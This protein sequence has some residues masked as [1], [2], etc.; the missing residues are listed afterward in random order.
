MPGDGQPRSREHAPSRAKFSRR[1]PVSGLPMPDSVPV[2][3]GRRIW[4]IVR[5]IWITLGLTFLVVFTTW[6]LL[7]YRASSE[8]EAAL[9]STSDVLVNDDS[10][11]WRFEPLPAAGASG[12]AL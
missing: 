7:A 6:S 5:K 12:A 10:G 4:V 2:T 3:R 8:A 9:E 11:V 1:Q